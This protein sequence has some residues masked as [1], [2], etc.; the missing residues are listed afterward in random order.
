M[1]PSTSLPTSNFNV[2][3]LS[4]ISRTIL[5]AVA[6][7]TTVVVLQLVVVQSGR[8]ESILSFT[9]LA[10]HSE[11]SHISID[12]FRFNET[13]ENNAASSKVLEELARLRVELETARERLRVLDTESI[14]N[15]P[16]DNVHKATVQIDSITQDSYVPESLFPDHHLSYDC[17]GGTIITALPSLE[18]GLSGRIFLLWFVAQIASTLKR[19][20]FSKVICIA[21]SPLPENGLSSDSVISA[22]HAFNLESWTRTLSLSVVDPIMCKD[23][24]AIA[25]SSQHKNHSLENTQWTSIEASQ[26]LRSSIPTSNGSEVLSAHVSAPSLTSVVQLSSQHLSDLNKSSPQCVAITTLRHSRSFPGELEFS[27]Q[28]SV[29]YL[30][31]FSIADS[32]T[33]RVESQYGSKPAIVFAKTANFDRCETAQ[34][35]AKSSSYVCIATAVE[36]G[37]EIFSRALSQYT[38]GMG[39]LQTY[40]MIGRREHM[41]DDDE[42]MNK[43]AEIEDSIQIHLT[44]ISNSSIVMSDN[45]LVQFPSL[46]P[47]A[48]L[49]EWELAVRAHAF[50]GPADSDDPWSASVRIARK[51]R[52]IHAPPD[53]AYWTSVLDRSVPHL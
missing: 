6:F 38:M 37:V 25:L 21:S 14:N 40:V 51:A 26:L 50:I 29:E 53:A 39:I 2:T 18:T 12:T 27:S 10:S 31:S 4:S 43:A 8:I 44:A 17:A 23:P 46:S 48:A 9:P 36:V 24:L 22:H 16:S 3:P 33:S 20:Q 1:P 32:V 49:V 19:N 35:Q 11:D 34:S 41:K 15:G 13:T 45:V 7:A 28:S 52:N 30:S 47:F 42:D 5:S